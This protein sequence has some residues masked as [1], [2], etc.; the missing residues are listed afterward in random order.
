[1]LGTFL[2]GIAV[3]I[4]I[5]YLARPKQKYTLEDVIS[6]IIYGIIPLCEEDDDY[7][8]PSLLSLV[9]CRLRELVAKIESRIREQNQ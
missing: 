3:G 7:F 1:M 2:S 5:S 9:G 8:A 4:M 6:D